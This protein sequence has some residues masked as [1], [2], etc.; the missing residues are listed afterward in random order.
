[1]V[2]KKRSFYRKIFSFFLFFLILTLTTD[3]ASN[4]SLITKEN[5]FDYNPTGFLIFRES[6]NSKSFNLFDLDNS[7]AQVY[8]T[9]SYTQAICDEKNLCKDFEF[10]CY[11]EKI[12]EIISTESSVQFPKNWEDLRPERLKD[13]MC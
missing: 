9:H 7:N 2:L 4:L 11:N 3:S 5:K 8:F 13:N 1:M 10:F 12:V 6:Q